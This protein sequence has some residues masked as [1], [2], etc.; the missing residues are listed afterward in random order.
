MNNENAAQK[1]WSSFLIYGMLILAVLVGMFTSAYLA[2]KNKLLAREMTTLVDSHRLK[3][4][5]Y[6]PLIPLKALFPKPGQAEPQLGN[7]NGTLVYVFSATCKA[8]QAQLPTLPSILES[9]AQYGYEVIA[10]STDGST[11][12]S[13]K[14]PKEPPYTV[15]YSYKADVFRNTHIDATPTY[16]LLNPEGRVEQ[17]HPGTMTADSFKATF[18]PDHIAAMKAHANDLERPLVSS[19]RM[20]VLTPQAKA[21]KYSGDIVASFMVDEQGN[22]QNIHLLKNPGYGLDQAAIS[23]IAA[24][25]YK[26]ATTAGVPRRAPLVMSIHF[27][28]SDPD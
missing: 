6:M 23:A 22:P 21:S 1:D 20:P 14:Y 19:F 13:N 3:Q 28:D 17:I 7:A 4:N 24:G 9:A 12:T 5:D 15:A 18:S 27:S 10:L 8:C 26:P 2:K 25:R 16:V 11:E